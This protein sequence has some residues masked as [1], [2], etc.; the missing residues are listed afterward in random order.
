MKVCKFGEE[1]F[2]FWKFRWWFCGAVKAFPGPDSQPAIS[3]PL[4]LYKSSRRSFKWKSALLLGR[5]TNLPC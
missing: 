4:T 1:K 3:S 2:L 5:E